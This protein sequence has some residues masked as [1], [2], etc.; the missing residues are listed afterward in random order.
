MCMINFF[1][2]FVFYFLSSTSVLQVFAFPC[3][4]F[5]SSGLTSFAFHYNGFGFSKNKAYN[6]IAQ[7]QQ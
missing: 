2:F 3:C 1:Y 7:K 6:G 5:A 4:S